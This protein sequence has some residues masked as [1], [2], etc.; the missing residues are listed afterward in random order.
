MKRRNRTEEQVDTLSWVE[1][2]SEVEFAA[3]LRRQAVARSIRAWA[4][5]WR[6]SSDA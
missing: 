1:A 2:S 5:A 3:R 6:K 4:A